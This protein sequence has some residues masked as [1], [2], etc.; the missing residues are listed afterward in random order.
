MQACPGMLYTRAM[1]IPSK[2]RTDSKERGA[3][4][5]PSDGCT[6]AGTGAGQYRGSGPAVVSILP[7]IVFTLFFSRYLVSGLVKGAIKE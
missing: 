5:E 7:A 2:S 4:R 3:A 1:D 6:H